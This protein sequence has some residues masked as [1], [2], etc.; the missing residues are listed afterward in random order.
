MVVGNAFFKQIPINCVTDS[1]KRKA[2]DRDNLDALTVGKRLKRGKRLHD[3][4]CGIPSA[5]LLNIICTLPFT[6]CGSYGA[7]LLTV[8]SAENACQDN[9][10]AENVYV[11]QLPQSCNNISWLAQGD[12]K[13]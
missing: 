9:M 11:Q 1:S 10:I 13:S 3:E 6:Q 5:T 4:C 8:G 7:A 12:L 2:A